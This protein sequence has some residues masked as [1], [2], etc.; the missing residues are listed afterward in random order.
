MSGLACVI[1]YCAA[2]W[3]WQDVLDW[4]DATLARHK[5]TDRHE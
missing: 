2:W 1:G 4:I 3:L 5:E